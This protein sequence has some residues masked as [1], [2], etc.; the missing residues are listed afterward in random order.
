MK[1][2]PVIIMA[3][4]ALAI[5]L[6]FDYGYD[7]GMANG[8]NQVNQANQDLLNKMEK[9]KQ[10]LANDLSQLDQKYTSDMVT[11]REKIDD[12]KKQAT[13]YTPPQKNECDCSDL[14]N[15]WVRVH[16]TAASV[17]GIRGASATSVDDG[18]TEA[19]KNDRPDHSKKRAIEVI[20]DNYAECSIYINQLEALQGFVKTLRA[21]GLE[22]STGGED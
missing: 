20:T 14:D 16:D 6:A 18:Q 11:M 12:A 5:W 19:V 4:V 7:S 22:S 13:K 1:W 2:R 8:L 3:I 21:N 15:E 17:S 9:E 10:A